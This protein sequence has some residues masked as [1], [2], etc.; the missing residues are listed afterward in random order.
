MS[1]SG[2]SRRGFLK[3]SAGAAAGTAALIAMQGT[4][5]G[6]AN[7]SADDSNH[8]G[9]RVT[10]RIA[11]IDA[12]ERTIRVTRASAD[13][14][15][16]AVRPDARMSRGW[17]ASF[18]DFQVR[19]HVTATGE[20]VGTVL[21]A[22]TLDGLLR[23]VSAQVLDRRQDELVTDLGRI[24]LTNRTTAVGTRA[25]ST[26]R[27]GDSISALVVASDTTDDRWLAV[28]VA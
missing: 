4:P 20:F 12:A 26:I 24:A 25:V 22:G 27:A 16:I 1:Q 19:D 6:A 21:G 2:V 10:G 18:D 17:D 11:A 5:V 8:A 3:G 14:A 28:Q 13:D 7:E 15:V 9:S 23:S